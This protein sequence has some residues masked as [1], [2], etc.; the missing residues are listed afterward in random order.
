LGSPLYERVARELVLTPAGEKLAAFARDTE[1]L[2]DELLAQLGDDAGRVTISAGRAALL[3]VLGDALGKAVRAGVDVRVMPAGR[4]AALDAV[5][6]GEADVAAIAFDPPPRGLDHLV[7]G[8]YPQNLLVARSHPLARR[9]EVQ[10][11]DLD[12]LRLVVP[13]PGR[14]H[15]QS[16]DRA[17]SAQNVSWV[18]AAEADGWDLLVHLAATGLGAAVVNGCVPH[19]RGLVGVPVADLPAVRYWLAWRPERARTVDLILD[20]VASSA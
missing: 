3:W 2:A 17:L 11:H 6:T 9:R 12:G 13:P 20:R 19:P 14:P 18:A 7:L 8:E 16:L 15:R 1:R 10:L 5:R 4:E